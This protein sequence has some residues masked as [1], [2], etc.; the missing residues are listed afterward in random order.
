MLMHQLHNSK[1]TPTH[2]VNF[3][4]WLILSFLALDKRNLRPFCC[5]N[6]QS[7]KA[8][9]FCCLPCRKSICLYGWT[10]HHH[11]INP[12]VIS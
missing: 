3:M 9:S 6:S 7:S 8:G 10:V 1:N 4:F 2:E 5:V 12:F 11:T